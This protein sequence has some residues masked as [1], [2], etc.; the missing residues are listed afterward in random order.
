M[1]KGSELNSP[2]HLQSIRQRLGRIKRI[3]QKSS[4]AVA[5]R[6][7]AMPCARL[8][9]RVTGLGSPSDRQLVLR[10]LAAT[11][12]VMRSALDHQ[13]WNIGSDAQRMRLSRCR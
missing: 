12:L 1:A 13:G 6:N 4:A 9:L 11:L 5:G 2:A 3:E 10:R 8:P 7:C